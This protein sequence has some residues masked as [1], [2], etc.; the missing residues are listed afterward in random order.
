VAQKCS[1]GQNAISRQSTKILL[2]KFQDLQGKDFPTVLENFAETFSLFQ[3]LQLF[4]IQ[5]SIPY[6]NITP[7]KWTDSRL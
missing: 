1:A 2:Q 5:Y 4:A 3:E 7:K 6:F